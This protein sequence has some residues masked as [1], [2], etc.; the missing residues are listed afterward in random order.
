MFLFYLLQKNKTDS[1][2]HLHHLLFQYEATL[3]D[4]TMVRNSNNFKTEA[5]VIFVKSSTFIREIMHESL[6]N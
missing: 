6:I 2:W 4:Y 1:S 3:G 5:M